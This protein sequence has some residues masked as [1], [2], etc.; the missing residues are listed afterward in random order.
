MRPTL[1]VGGRRLGQYLLGGLET[2]MF[3]THLGAHLS[4]VLKDNI[5][6]VGCALSGPATKYLLGFLVLFV[7]QRVADAH[8]GQ[9]PLQVDLVVLSP[10]DLRRLLCVL[11]L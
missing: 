3:A 5:E 6:V 7:R 8:T 4:V 10:N 9:A 2:S 11:R 1:F